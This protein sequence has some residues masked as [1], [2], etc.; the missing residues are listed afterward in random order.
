MANHATWA[1]AISLALLAGCLNEPSGNPDSLPETPMDTPVEVASA[2][3]NATYD[4]MATR[5]IPDPGSTLVYGLALGE[6]NCVFFI[7][8]EAGSE[9]H[10]LRGNA[11]LEWDSSE[12]LVLLLHAEA[13]GSRLDYQATENETKPGPSPAMLEFQELQVNWTSPFALIAR[14]APM[15]TTLMEPVRL[16]VSFEYTGAELRPMGPAYCSWGDR[17]T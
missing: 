2:W 1:A 10:V 11:T 9:L 3:F 15:G 5:E 14:V 7:P 8:D 16:H 13:S 4:L 6:R 17:V 12:S